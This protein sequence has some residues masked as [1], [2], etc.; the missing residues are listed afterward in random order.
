M[1]N[2]PTNDDLEFCKNIYKKL[3]G[4][5][6]LKEHQPTFEYLKKQTQKHLAA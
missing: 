3:M 5:T 1:N 2:A 6:L 4:M